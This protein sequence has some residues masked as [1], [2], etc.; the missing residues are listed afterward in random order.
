MQ[1]TAP[2]G[3]LT[4]RA[5]GAYLPTMAHGIKKG[6]GRDWRKV[7]R[8][9]KA[10]LA[11]KRDEAKALAPTLVDA[12]NSQVSRGD[13]TLITRGTGH[14]LIPANVNAQV[15]AKSNKWMPLFLERLALTGL[16]GASANSVGISRVT[17]YDRR[18]TDPIFAQ[19]WDDAMDDATDLMEQAAFKRAVHGVDEPVW[20]RGDDGRPVKVDIIKRYSD[21]L[22]ELLLKAHRPKKYNDRVVTEV[23]GPGGGTIQ[24]E[25][26]EV[27]QFDWA[28]YAKLAQ[29]LFG[30]PEGDNPSES[31]HPARPNGKAGAV[32]GDNGS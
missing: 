4:Q 27:K 2:R 10:E 11:A 9:T 12:G 25:Q 14:A 19:A 1:H 15:W 24:V 3:R 13:E 32:S 30:S 21:R 18:N 26:R 8:T 28:A 29:Q 17:A 7:K 6:L 20:M 22:L 23:S 16:V 31:V 5:Q